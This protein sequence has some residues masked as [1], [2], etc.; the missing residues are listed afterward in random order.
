MTVNALHYDPDLED[1][2]RRFTDQ[3]AKDADAAL[4]TWSEEAG[5]LPSE[6]ARTVSRMAHRALTWQGRAKLSQ[7]REG[8]ALLMSWVADHHRRPV[9]PRLPLLSKRLTYQYCAELVDQRGGESAA[10]ALARGHM[11][12]L[13]LRRETSTL[14]NHGWGAY[15]DY[16]VVLNG[17][18]GQRAAR[19]FPAATEPSAQYAH[20]ASVLKDGKRLDPAYNNVRFRKIE[21]D[22]VNGDGIRDAGRL[23]AGTYFYVE[24]TGGYM[25]DRAFQTLRSQTAERDTNGDSFFTAA[26]GDRI[27]TKFV[28]TSMLIH[29][30]GNLANGNTGSAGCQTIPSDCYASF[31]A[32]VGRNPRFHYVL[33]DGY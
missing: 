32:A 3:A 21:G 24:R 12:L 9:L 25:K 30:G 29:K 31:L 7:R 18:A 22:D 28:G 1:L 19:V 33:V 17:P 4:R 27:D 26:D 11:V 23:K 5:R 8:A 20:R 16:I 2:A 15:D 6:I 14:V 10:A 13:G